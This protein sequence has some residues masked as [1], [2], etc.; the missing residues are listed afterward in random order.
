MN[1]YSV[2]L[3]D[4]EKWSLFDV[5]HTCPFE[6]FGF[7]IVGENTNAVNA[8]DAIMQLKPDVVFVDIRMPSISGI[9]LIHMAKPKIPDTVF[10]I[11]SGYAEFEYAAN[12]LR[13]GVFDYCL[14]PM[15]EDVAR[16][17][18][19]R[20]AAHMEQKHIEPSAEDVQEEYISGSAQFT[21]LLQHVNEHINDQLVL[22]DLAQQFF[23][24]VSYCGELF[25]SVTGDNFTLYVRKRRM[26]QACE[27]LARTNIPMSQVAVRVGYSDLPYFSRLF[28]A[29][30]GISP[31]RYRAANKRWETGIESEKN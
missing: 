30:M 1:L 13:M 10:I 5:A 24:N 12:A 11:L 14:K 20:L 28:T 17:L 7:K 26:Q 27:L 21:A 15:S 6:E 4:D 31:S 16:E 22:G 2:Y 8:M 29:S 3:I 25:K 19:Q 23:I 18:L 9:D